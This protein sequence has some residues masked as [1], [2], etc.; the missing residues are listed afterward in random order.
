ML[1]NP[2]NQFI[3]RISP[4]LRPLGGTFRCLARRSVQQRPGLRLQMR[5]LLELGFPIPTY[6]EPQ[7]DQRPDLARLSQALGPH[8]YRLCARPGRSLAMDPVAEVN[9]THFVMID[10]D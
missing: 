10:F 9:S 7:V 2:N 8:L 1:P 4:S 6:L 3:W 5:R